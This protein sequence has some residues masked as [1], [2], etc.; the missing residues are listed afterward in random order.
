MPTPDINKILARPENNACSRRGAQMGRSSQTEGKPERLYLQRIHYEDGCYDR[1]GAYWGGPS[2]T[3]GV[4]W[5][6]FSSETTRNEIP[7]RVFV[8][9][10]DRDEAKRKVLERL[11]G[12]GWSFFR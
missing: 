3:M 8:R 5:C 9:A 10:R 6:A 2:P 12:E 4:M 11:P 7:I 1:G